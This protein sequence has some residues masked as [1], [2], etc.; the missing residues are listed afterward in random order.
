MTSALLTFVGFVACSS[1]PDNDTRVSVTSDDTAAVMTTPQGRSLAGL[2]AIADSSGSFVIIAVSDD[3]GHTAVASGVD[4]NGDPV[5]T[6]D[7]FALWSGTK[8][9][10]AT[11]AL[12]ALDDGLIDL[13]QPIEEYVEFPFPDD[14]T[15]RHLLSH[16]SGINYET[17]L[18]CDPAE[19][20]D[21]L[22]TIAELTQGV[23]PGTQASYS[24]IGFQLA[25]LVLNSVH[26][27]PL[28]EVMQRDMFDPLDMSSTYFMET[29]DGNLPFGEYDETV[30]CPPG[31]PTIGAQGGLITT[32]G[33][34]ET[35]LRALHEDDLLS[36][37]SHDQMLTQES[38]VNGIDYGLGI[39]LIYARDGSELLRYGHN[40]SAGYDAG[41][42]FEPAEH[43]TIVLVTQGGDW[44][45][46]VQ[47]I[48]EWADL[49]D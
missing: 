12:R 37:S 3:R 1:E 45:E 31:S 32:A 21:K 26:D 33:D 24:N 17:E 20:I 23:E 11:A 4:F 49:D 8:L 10:T 5:S 36:P 28:S 39:G 47:H 7:A 16:T 6:E 42:V 40:G 13:D 30:V 44:W 41:G 22:Q 25:G 46:I 43:R 34:L 29:G 15:M 35:F 48:S 27:Q 19:N 2:Q 14:V 38:V 18:V 9:F